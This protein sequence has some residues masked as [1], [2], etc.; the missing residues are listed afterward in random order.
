MGKYVQLHWNS[1][2]KPH[3]DSKKPLSDQKGSR[4]IFVFITQK[5][6]LRTKEFLKIQYETAYQINIPIL[7]I[8][9]KFSLFWNYCLKLVS[10]YFA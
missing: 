6:I 1:N 2:K 5:D 7:I 3:H 10:E 4:N 9:L 8:R